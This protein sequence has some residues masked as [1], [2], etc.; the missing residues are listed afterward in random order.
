MSS[1]LSV[2]V[3]YVGR[4]VVNRV[5]PERALADPDPVLGQA[6]FQAARATAIINQQLDTVQNGWSVRLAKQF[7][8]QT[9]RCELL[10]VHYFERNDFFLRP[11]IMYA[12]ADG[13]EATVGGEIFHGPE[14]SFFGRIQDNTGAFVELRYS[15]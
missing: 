11:K 6:R 14:R 12:L 3:Q 15:F 10:G 7:W 9:L 13:W 5:D 8:N 2:I 4:Y 1:D